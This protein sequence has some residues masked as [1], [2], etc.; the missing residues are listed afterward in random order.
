MKKL[1]IDT[2]AYKRTVA[3]IIDDEIASFIEEDN[4]T[5]LSVRML[6]MLSEAISAAKI[7]PADIDEI[8]VV[9]GP[10]SFTGIRVGVT[11]AKVYAWALKKKI[12]PLSE[13]ELLAT[14]PSTAD[15]IIPYIDARRDY[16]YTAI[17]DKDLNIIMNPCH[18]SREELMKHIPE[19]KTVN[20]ISNDNIDTEYPILKPDCDIL[21][22]LNLHK[23]DA[24]INPHQCN[25]EYLKMTEAEENLLKKDQLDV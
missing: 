10:G 22:I 12:V 18:I 14:T 15:I 1:F 19:G 5:N 17:Y 16:G 7:T 23:N 11:I 20:F 9:N 2:A 4:D 21:K 13:L 24:G 8:Y 6:P 25:P 3:V